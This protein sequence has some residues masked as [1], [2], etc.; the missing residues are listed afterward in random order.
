MSYDHPSMLPP[1]GP[2]PLR[3]LTNAMDYNNSGEPVV[4]VHVDGISLEGDVIVSNVTVDNPTSNPVNV[5]V[6]S[7]NVNAAVTGTVT[8]S[9]ITNNV[10]IVDG[11]GS[12]TVDGTVAVSGNISGITSL[13]PITGTV[14]ANITGGN[15]RVTQGTDPWNVAGTIN[16]ITT[17]GPG[18]S[19]AFGRTR[20]SEPFT[21]GDYKHLYGLDPNFIDY[22]VNGGNIAFQNNQACARLTTS[23]N[24]SSRSVH[25]T[26]FYHHYMPGKSQLILASF[27]FYSAVNN[28]T[29]RTGYFDDRNGI[30]FEQTGDGTLAMV[31]RSYVT[32]SPADTR[33]SQQGGVYGAG[34][35]GWNGDPVDGSGAS[36]WDM[37]ITK[38]QLWWCDFQWL[39]V[40]RVR[41][42][43][44]HDEQY[45]VCHTFYHSDNLN[46]VY[47]S[48]PNLPIRCEIFNTGATAGGYF[49]QICTTVMSEGGYVEAGQDWG[50][51][52]NGTLRTIAGGATVPVLAIKLKNT[53]RGYDHNRIIA[54][55]ENLSVFTTTENVYFRV[56]KLPN[57]AALTGNTWVEVD[58]DSGMQYNVTATTFSSANEDFLIAGYSPAGTSNG[59]GNTTQLSTPS[60]AKKNYI[61]QNFDSTDSEIYAVVVTNLS[62]SQSTQVGATIQWR[63]IY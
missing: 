44:V 56:V 13:P 25:Q 22:M 39:G 5:R 47:M 49:D 23:S 45:I 52:N 19:D 36:G 43:F 10:T 53:F 20:T 37:D 9:S 60:S 17:P 35:T 58:G 50:V 34:D 28:V 38:T 6:N 63:E 61:V 18:A 42:G 31:I 33:I 12:I 41:V 1:D 7:G 30:F 46:V 55:L 16:A 27:N 54:R 26:K 14:N 51:A 21:L 59:S 2:H 8:V 4:R 29:K 40:G 48:N 11:G 24:T 32:G 57:Q 62:A 15:V 3:D